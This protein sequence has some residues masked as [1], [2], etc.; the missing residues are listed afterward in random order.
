LANCVLC[1]VS[2]EEE[3]LLLWKRCREGDDSA[4]DRLILEGQKLVD[5]YVGRVGRV[6]RWANIQDLKQEGVKGV[7]WAVDHFDPAIGQSFGAFARQAIGGAI[8]RNPEVSRGLK[9][10]YYDLFKRVEAAQAKLEQVLM[11]Q[12]TA[13]EIAKEARLTTKQV[14]DAILAMY[15]VSA[16]SA[17]F[18]DPDKP[19]DIP[20]V[21]SPDLYTRVL[22]LEAIGVLTEQERVIVICYY[23]RDLTDAQIGA[24]LELSEDIVNQRRNAALAE[25]RRF[26]EKQ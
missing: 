4:R 16:D 19:A 26:L 5:L 21:R 3:E 12:P 1:G 14:H 10:E 7:I 8:S 6:A 13:E 22:V 24:E 11:R 23:W 15:L 25:M 17:P 9:R 18:S 2:M 20:D